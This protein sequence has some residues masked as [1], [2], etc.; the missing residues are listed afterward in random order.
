MQLIYLVRCFFLVRNAVFSLMLFEEQNLR[1]FQS[2]NKMSSTSNDSLSSVY[3]VSSFED[4]SD[5]ILIR[6]SSMEFDPESGI[7]AVS[8]HENV[9]IFFPDNNWSLL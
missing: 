4:K 7:F 2:P 5:H 6:Y 9:L 8:L 3:R 1:E